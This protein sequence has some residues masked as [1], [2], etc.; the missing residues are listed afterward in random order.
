MSDKAAPEPNRQQPDIAQIA[1]GPF[2]HMVAAGERQ[3]LSLGVPVDVMVRIMMQHA[4]S[5]LALVEPAGVRA[6]IMRNMIGNFPSM[7]RTAQ[8]AASKT[9]G[10]VILPR[11]RLPEE[12]NGVAP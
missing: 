12:G 1:L 2:D 9:P 5:I 7:V 8:L 11:A 6:E 10:G 3:L 4:A